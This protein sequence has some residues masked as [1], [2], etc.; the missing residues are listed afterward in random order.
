MGGGGLVGGV[1]TCCVALSLC[2]RGDSHPS[3]VAAQGG[4]GASIPMSCLGD[5][6]TLTSPSPNKTPAARIVV[7]RSKNLYIWIVY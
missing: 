2:Q 5:A 1:A 3:G 6:A 4:G 7:G